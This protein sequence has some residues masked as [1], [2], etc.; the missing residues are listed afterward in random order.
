MEHGITQSTGLQVV[1]RAAFEKKMSTQSMC[2]A[3]ALISGYAREIAGYKYRM[4]RMEQDE[5]ERLAKESR[6]RE[7]LADNHGKPKDYFKVP[8]LATRVRSFSRRF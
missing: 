4:Q 7:E 1:R 8:G 2:G 6:Y 3:E 5:I